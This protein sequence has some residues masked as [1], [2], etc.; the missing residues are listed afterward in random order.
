[1]STSPTVSPFVTAKIHKADFGATELRNSLRR[2][3]Y[4]LKQFHAGWTVD[5]TGKVIPEELREHILFINAHEGKSEDTSQ[6]VCG[7][8]G[9]K[10]SPYR[11][12][13]P[14]LPEGVDAWF[15]APKRI[16]IVSRHVSGMVTIREA[17]IHVSEA[18]VAT[19]EENVLFMG[20]VLDRSLSRFEDAVQASLRKRH[21]EE[22]NLYFAKEKHA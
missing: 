1:M 10:L 14:R 15:S 4:T 6:V 22:R 21:S 9:K 18:N 3:G 13:D 20:N 19:V 17:Y 8:S 7:L 12:L 11:K 2:Q 5:L 16:I